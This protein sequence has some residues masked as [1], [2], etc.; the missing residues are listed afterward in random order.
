MA[1]RVFPVGARVQ[2]I[3]D[4]PFREL[5]GT[6]RKVH[7]MHPFEGDEPFCYYW[8]ELEGA[9]IKE[10]IWFRC[11]EVEAVAPFVAREKSGAYSRE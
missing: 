2:V 6:I 8:I 4:S 9:F 1:W 5:R 7:T 3:S 10:P 11:D